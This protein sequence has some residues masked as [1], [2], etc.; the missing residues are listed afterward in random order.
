MAPRLLH[1]QCEQA[2]GGL[3]PG[4]LSLVVQWRHVE[5]APRALACAG[6]GSGGVY[7]RSKIRTNARG[8]VM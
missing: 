6:K 8:G 5:L 7:P 4:Q 2:P 1:L 3:G